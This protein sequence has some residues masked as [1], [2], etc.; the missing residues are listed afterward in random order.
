[1]EIDIAT[2]VYIDGL[3]SIIM[4]AHN[5]AK[6]ISE[7]IDSVLAQTYRNWELLIVNDCS[8]DTSVSIIDT[9]LLKD[10]RIKLFHTDIS[11]GKP[12]YPR[13]LALKNA[14][15]RFIAF[16]DSDDVWLPS[17]LEKQL[18]LFKDKDVAI[19]FSNYVKF[20]NDSTSSDSTRTILSA[21]ELTYKSA[22]YGNQI[23]NLT[24]VYDVSKVGKVEVL[25][26]GHEDYILWLMI[27]KK[28][29]IAKNTNSIEAKYRVSSNSISSDKHKASK[30]TWYIY[31][32]ILNMNIVTA[33][34]CYIRYAIRGLTNYFK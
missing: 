19:V 7:S 29:F 5:S 26:E 10:S 21:A 3:V 14:K 20:N 2:D 32:R 25:N 4:P 17:K 1:M 24:G 27:L 30:W 23:G 18:P 15:G 33:G 22:I 8:T 28:G 11:F 34:Y 9:Y 31:R 6:T 13:N 16:L 12:F